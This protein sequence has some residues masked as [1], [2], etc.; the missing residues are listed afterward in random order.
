M[1]AEPR[2]LPGA[3]GWERQRKDEL[4]QK[5]IVPQGTY[6]KIKDQVIAKQK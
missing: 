3:I 1:K 4:V 5:K 6:D 2:T